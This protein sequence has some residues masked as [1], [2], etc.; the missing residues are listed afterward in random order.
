MGHSHD[1][2]LQHKIE[3]N[4]CQKDPNNRN[5][6][7][8]KIALTSCIMTLFNPTISL[9]LLYEH[10]SIVF[11]FSLLLIV[12]IFQKIC[13]LGTNLA[14]LGRGRPPDFLCIDS[15]FFQFSNF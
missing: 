7:E 13:A 3:E 11:Y 1:V 2:G 12:V 5:L 4:P 14:A 6:C 10:G 8:N 15:N 9:F